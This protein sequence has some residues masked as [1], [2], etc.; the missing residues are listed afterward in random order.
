MHCAQIVFEE[1]GFHSYYACPA[2]LL[3]LQA[4]TWHNQSSPAAQAGCGLIVD[5]GFSFTHAVPIFDGRIMDQGVRRINLGGKVLTNYLKE[6]V[7][8]R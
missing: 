8:Y 3:S 1:F 5:A 4:H 2:P 7:T 6:L